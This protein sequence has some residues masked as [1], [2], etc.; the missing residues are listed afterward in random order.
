MVDEI[1]QKVQGLNSTPLTKNLFKV[2]KI[3][4]K[5]GQERKDTV[6]SF[7]MKGIFLCKDEDVISSLQYHF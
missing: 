6:H 4:K 2:D 7:V 3:W 5:L 1:P